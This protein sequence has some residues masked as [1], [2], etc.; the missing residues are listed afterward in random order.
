MNAFNA[1]NPVHVKWFREVVEADSLTSRI[2]KMEKNPMNVHYDR[3]YIVEHIF[4]LSMKYNQAFFKG[5]AFVPDDLKSFRG[6]DC[7][8]STGS[9]L[10]GAHSKKCEPQED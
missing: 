7:Q 4:G 5:E 2:E 9:P 1:S 6:C 3:V 10:C 8:K